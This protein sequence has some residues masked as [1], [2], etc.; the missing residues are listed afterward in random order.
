MQTQRFELKYLISERTALAI[1]DFVASYLEIDEHG[2]G[3]PNLAYSVHSLYLDSKDLYTHRQAVNGTRN[4]FKLRLRYYDDS[5]DSPVFFEIK[6]RVNNCILKQRGGVRR[7]AVGWLLA[8]HLPDAEHLVSGEPRHLV[9][10]QRF[11]LLMSQLQA[12]PTAHVYYDREAWVGPKDNAVRVTL[13]RGMHCVPCF[14][15]ELSIAR[16]GEILTF[17]DKV[18]LELKFTNYF[19]SWLK[20]MVRIYGL[21]QGSAAKYSEGIMVLGE[22]RFIRGRVSRAPVEPGSVVAEGTKFEERNIRF[23]TSEH[24]IA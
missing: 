2:A 24:Q 6:R 20:E 13:D 23:E 19:P 22:H 12:Q 8:G 21:M 1:R 14:T 5:P 16:T 3:R 10:L 15:A 9:A 4:R 18:I 17:G 11:N 7:E